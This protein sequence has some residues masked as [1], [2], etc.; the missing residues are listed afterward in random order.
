MSMKNVSQTLE[1]KKKELIKKTKQLD[2]FKKKMELFSQRELDVEQLSVGE[3]KDFDHQCTVIAD[4]IQQLPQECAQLESEIK[5]L[6]R[7]ATSK[8]PRLNNWSASY[9]RKL[10]KDQK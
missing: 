1:K 6:E 9:V 7:A 3:L 2:N 5:V 8:Q 4:R 10:K